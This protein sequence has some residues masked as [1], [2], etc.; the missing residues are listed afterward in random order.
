M[1]LGDSQANKLNLRIRYLQLEVELQ[2][3][4]ICQLKTLHETTKKTI[5]TRC[6]HVNCK[7]DHGRYNF[8]SFSDLTKPNL[9]KEAVTQKVH[10]LSDGFMTKC[11]RAIQRCQNKFGVPE[12]PTASLHYKC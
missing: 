9:P 6:G 10:A 3:K 12:P 11:V 8:V 4:I 5:P 1:C 2:N 7:I